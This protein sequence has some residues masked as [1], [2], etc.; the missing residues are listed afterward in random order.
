[1]PRLAIKALSSNRAW[2]GRHFKTQEYKDY[3]EIVLLML[4]RGLKVPEGKLKL[5]LEFGL[6]SKNAD[7]DNPI[8]QFADIL[9]KMYGFNDKHIYELS[10]KKVDVEKTKEYIAFEIT[11]L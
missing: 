5:E 7:I 1:M 8:K 6:S 4:P 10:V 11:K 9:Q 2:R 3:E